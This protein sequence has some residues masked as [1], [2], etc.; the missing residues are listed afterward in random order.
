M[1]FLIVLLFFTVLYL[2]LHFF[3]L[4]IIYKKNWEG[5]SI[6][7]YLIL[8]WHFFGTLPR[9]LSLKLLVK[10]LKTLGSISSLSLF[11]HNFKKLNYLL[12]FHFYSLSTSLGSKSAWKEI[13]LLLIKNKKTLF[14]QMKKFYIFKLFLKTINVTKKVNKIFTN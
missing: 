3:S 5:L 2:F 1:T 9:I 6:F 14:L 4:V 11:N 8:K 10:H 12:S 13:N 7:W